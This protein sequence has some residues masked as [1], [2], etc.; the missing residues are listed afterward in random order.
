MMPAMNPGAIPADQAARRRILE[1][2]DACLL[3]EAGAGS[4]KTT[5]L[6]GRMLQLVLR[7]EP[8]EHIAAVTFTRKAASELRERFQV[9]LEKSARGVE[10]GSVAAE[11]LN[12]ALRE[13]DRAFLGTIHSF[14][15]RL[16]RE[17]PLEVGLDPAFH[18]VTEEDWEVL[19][20][21]FW[22][23][24]LERSRRAENA[25]LRD[26]QAA[27][28]EPRALYAAFKRVVDYPDVSFPLLS[29]AIPDAGA[30]RREL[31]RLLGRALAMLP[32]AEPAAGWDPLQRLVRR[33]ARERRLH[34]RGWEDVAVFCSVIERIKA[35]HLKLTQ[36]RWSADKDGKERA[37]ELGADFTTF[38]EDQAS[39]L[40]RCWREHRYPLVMRLLLAA[41][42]D[43]QAERLATGQ[44]GFEDLLLLTA[45][46]LREHPLVRDELGSRWR[47]LLVDEFQDTDPVQA[48]VC[49]LLSS[50]SS[51][52]DDWRSVVPRPG[53]LF[54]VGD[55]KQSIYRFRRADIQI[56]DLVKRRFEAFGGVLALTENFRSVHPIGRLV[57]EHFAT[58]FPAS[59]T[60][61][62]APFSEMRT[63]HE[64][65]GGDGVHRYTVC[66]DARNNDALFE[67]DSAMLAS[68]IAARVES[69]AYAPGDFLILTATRAPIEYYARALAVRNV[70]VSTTGARL[71]QEHEL[72]ELLVV[73]RAIADPENAVLVA[74]ALEGLFFGL[75][76]ADLY[77]A[78]LAGQRFSIT[79]PPGEA[80]TA[81]A[82][83]LRQLHQWWRV[84]Q[85][86]AADVLFERILDDTGL[87]VH[88]AVQP[89]GDARAGALLH[90]VESLRAAAVHGGSA[91]T[92]AMERIEVLL[93]AEAPDAPLRPGR[94]DAVRVMNLHKAKGLEARVVM[95]AAPKKDTSYEPVAHVRRDAEGANGWLA[96]SAGGILVAQPPGWAAMAAEETRFLD[97]EDGRLLYV[98]ATRA[99]QEL[100]VARCE[101]QT[102]A[103]GKE[104]EKS[105]WSPLESSLDKHGTDISISVTPAPG[106]RVVDRSA[107]D[108]R[109]AVARVGQR[110]AA[111]CS[112]SLRAITVTES[113][114]AERDVQRQY[115][116]PPTPGMGAAWGRAVHRC[117]EAAARGRDGDNLDAFTRAVA[118]EEMLDPDG[119]AKLAELVATVRRSDIWKR[120][121]AGGAPM[122]ELPIM[123]LC[124]TGDDRTLIEGV[125]DVA[126]R[127][128]DG[129][130]VVDWK[131]DNVADAAWATRL[132]AYERQVSTYS[133]ML[134]A[135]CG[136]PATGRIERVRLEP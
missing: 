75:T 85:R 129:L 128:P 106:R 136:Q 91:V 7:G 116:L 127:E 59:G 107:D 97:A 133:S 37:K 120:I 31:D 92:D 67:Q 121:V 64:P 95:L 68:L 72:R 63:R 18:E 17:R 89:L 109:A 45:R 11:R 134:T 122:L 135:L 30:C 57:N 123:Q 4:G 28:V 73:L 101:K 105:A 71:P 96:I 52:G 21:G 117:L 81:A 79:H 66:P 119:E 124:E 76:P 22:S 39:D 93:A 104:Y 19:Q 10:S 102:K 99:R 38:L 12:R 43:F 9:Q 70:P 103:R 55:P 1:D 6:V 115:D 131:T 58:V 54:V 33:L 51:E 60:I 20:Q 100:F 16:L 78:R 14:C 29:S 50:E 26:A 118:A 49:L 23:R 42:K 53:A 5:S 36:N 110:R 65:A 112:T 74:A 24:W 69:G 34:D 3:V 2:L 132:T 35:S 125:I 82:N 80:P 98:A 94:R 41:A 77:E 83:A 88:A 130:L 44:L 46:L 47:R 114:K 15:A 13:L 56:Y 87:L 108:V 90:L 84:S 48:E 111:G 126:V 8:V 113:A 61:E 32:P 40:L 86:Q 62:Q 27:G 25:D